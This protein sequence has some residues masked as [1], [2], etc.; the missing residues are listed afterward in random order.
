MLCGA[1]SWTQSSLCVP[2]ILGYSVLLWSWATFALEGRT[3]LRMVGSSPLWSVWTPLPVFWTWS[4]LLSMWDL[5]VPGAL[6]NN[7]CQMLLTPVRIS[8]GLYLCHA[9]RWLHFIYLQ[10][11]L[12]MVLLTHRPRLTSSWA[13]ENSPSSA[14]GR[15]ASQAQ[16]QP[17]QAAGNSVI[18]ISRDIASRWW[19]TVLP[20]C[21]IPASNVLWHSHPWQ[22]TVDLWSFP[23]ILI[24]PLL[25]FSECF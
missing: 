3:S 1:R 13:C 9:T 5:L 17:M 16:R 21:A 23:I 8:Y 25:T 18:N 22:G 10:S 12:H 11:W 7:Y 14:R 2:S 4:K 20:S 15:A 6:A 24:Y 19:Q